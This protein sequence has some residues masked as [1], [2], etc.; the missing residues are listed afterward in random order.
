MKLH[1]ENIS[2]TKTWVILVWQLL[3]AI[4]FVS[5]GIMIVE[6]ALSLFS[7]HTHLIAT[8]FYRR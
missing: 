7:P 2:S 5:V 6:L 3:W 4:I 1:S 8:I